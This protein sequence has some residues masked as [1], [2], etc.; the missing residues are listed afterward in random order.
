[1]VK[2]VNKDT[3][4]ELRERTNISLIKCKQALIQSN[5]NIELALNN[6]RRSGL[7]ID[8]NK[9]N[10]ITSSGLV[11]VKIASNQHK[12]C[13]VEVNC[14]T[15]FVSRNDVFQKFVKTVVITVLDESINDLNLLKTR[16]NKERLILINQV[17]ENIQINRLMILTGNFLSSYTHR[18]K[19]GV[20]VSTDS[21]CDINII[22]QI[23]MH[24][25]A[26]NPK[27]ICK[28]DIPTDIL[29]SER[30]IQMDIAMKSKKSSKILEKIVKGRIEKFICDV[31]LMNQPFI[32]DMNKNVEN[33]LNEH[34]IKINNFIRLELGEY[35]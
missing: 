31:V 23:A 3:I 29:D 27:Y 4:K 21:I 24:I 2:N 1:M 6:L 22:K 16:F 34:H 12:G 28:N 33:I 11:M 9:L 25:A 18:S 14:E 30:C 13:I 8:R 7:Q 32:L 5:G 15:D 20:I 17:G 26:Q 19:I 10:K 35:S